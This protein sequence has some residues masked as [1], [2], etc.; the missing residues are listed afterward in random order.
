MLAGATSKTIASSIC[1]PHE[2]ARTRMREEGRKYR[3]FW[4]TL[5]LVLREEGWG[6]LYRGLATQLVRQIPNTAIMMAT[7]EGVVYVLTRHFGE[8]DSEFYEDDG[9]EDDMDDNSAE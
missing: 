6:G 2:V 9:Y 3:G 5:G 1:Y 4:Q 7:Y 8:H